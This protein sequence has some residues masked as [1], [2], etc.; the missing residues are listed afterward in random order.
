M[1]MGFWNGITYLT[2]R[3]SRVV[4]PGLHLVPGNLTQGWNETRRN[5]LSSILSLECFGGKGLWNLLAFVNCLG[6]L[7]KRK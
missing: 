1:R 4:I 5:G 6:S 7:A 2:D 3:I